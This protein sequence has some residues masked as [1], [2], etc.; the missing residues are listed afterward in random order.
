EPLVS[1]NPI[2]E[3]NPRMPAKKNILKKG[4][5]GLLVPDVKDNSHF[6]TLIGRLQKVCHCAASLELAGVDMV[7][8][9]E[10]P[11]LASNTFRKLLVFMV[12]PK[13]VLLPDLAPKLSFRPASAGTDADKPHPNNTTKGHARFATGDS[14]HC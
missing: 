6:W 13:G 2:N 1:G 5:S 11:A 12:I 4:R 3:T 8:N 10:L 14:R 9:H 7:N